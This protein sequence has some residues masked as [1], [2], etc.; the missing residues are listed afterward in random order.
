MN[1]VKH[2]VRRFD[3][4]RMVVTDTQ[5]ACDLHYFSPAEKVTEFIAGVLLPTGIYACVPCIKAGI[6]HAR[7]HGTPIAGDN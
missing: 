6:A 7:K 2:I 5:E 1:D 3:D 4:A